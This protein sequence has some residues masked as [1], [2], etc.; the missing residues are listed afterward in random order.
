MSN[1]LPKIDQAGKP[2][3][4]AGQSRDDLDLFTVPGTEIVLTDAG[5]GATVWQWSI[6]DQPPGAA[7]TLTTP[8]AMTTNLTN[9]TVRG[10]YFVQL[11]V[12]GGALPAQVYRIIAGVQID[13][14][15]WVTPP[16]N[17]PLRIPAKG[18]TTEF[19][20]ESSPGAGAN[21]RGWAQ[22][23]DHW[24]RAI[25]AF[26]FGVRAQSGGVGV[27]T[28]PFYTLNFVGMT[29]ADAG[30]GVLNVT[31][32]NGVTVQDE[33]AAVGSRPIINFIGAGVSAVDNPGNNRIDVTIPGGLG[34]IEVRNEG[35][36]PIP[37]GPWSQFQFRVPER[38]DPNYFS[39]ATNACAQPGVGEAD[40]VVTS[41]HHQD[42]F[43]SGGILFFEPLTSSRN[44][45]K[46][47]VVSMAN[48]MTLNFLSLGTSGAQTKVVTQGAIYDT[49]SIPAGMTLSLPATTGKALKL[50]VLEA[51]TS[52]PLVGEVDL[53]VVRTP[54]LPLVITDLHRDFPDRVVTITCSGG[55][56]YLSLDGGPLSLYLSGQ[57]VRL[58]D[59]SGY[60]WVEVF[61]SGAGI[62]GTEMWDIT[63]SM[64]R[65]R[66]FC[67]LA[68]APYW[69]NGAVSTWGVNLGG[70]QWVI[71]ARQFGSI[72]ATELQDTALQVID[73][74]GGDM[75]WQAGVVFNHEEVQ[76]DSANEKHLDAFALVPATSGGPLQEAVQVRGG[77]VWAGGRRYV[78]D[79]AVLVAD[80]GFSDEPICIVAKLSPGGNRGVGITAFQVATGNP[81]DAVRTCLQASKRNPF[82]P[83]M[84][85]ELYV[86]LYFGRV[87]VAG[88]ALIADGRV[89]LRRD[90]AHYGQWTVA[91]RDPSTATEAFLGLSWQSRLGLMIGNNWSTAGKCIAEFGSVAGALAWH[92]ALTGSDNLTPLAPPDSIAQNYPPT[93][94]R[95]IGD[96][97]ETFPIH[98]RNN[99]TVRGEGSPFVFVA[100]SRWWIDYGIP[101][102]EW[103]YFNIGDGYTTNKF[104]FNVELRD[105]SIIMTAYDRAVQG[106]GGAIS[107]ALMIWAGDYNSA[108]TPPPTGSWT[109]RGT[110]QNV[111]VDNVGFD[112]CDVSKMSRNDY[113]AAIC[114][115]DMDGPNA[116][117]WYNGLFIRNCKTPVFA[118]RVGD[119]E[120]AFNGAIYVHMLNPAWSSDIGIEHCRFSVNAFGIMSDVASTLISG[121]LIDSNTIE[122]VLYSMS[123]ITSVTYGVYF[124]AASVSG[125]RVHNNDFILRYSADVSRSIRFGCSLF[126]SVI[127][128]NREIENNG[129][130]SLSSGIALVGN[131]LFRTSVLGNQVRCG[132]NGILIDVPAAYSIQTLR[133][134]DNNVECDG[135]S[136]TTPAGIRILHPS[137]SSTGSVAVEN[138]SVLYYQNGIV[139]EFGSRAESISVAHN[140]VVSRGG[141][142]YADPIGISFTATYLPK[143]VS[144]HG[145]S[146]RDVRRGIYMAIPA[147]ASDV[148]IKDNKID[149]LAMTTEIGSYN[150]RGIHVL[151]TPSADARVG[152]SICDNVIRN[153][154]SFSSLDSL[155]GGGVVVEN[156]DTFLLSD[157]SICGNDIMM[158]S[159]EADMTAVNYPEM[160][161]V[162][163]RGPIRGVQINKNK[164]ANRAVR[165]FGGPLHG[166]VVIL[167]NTAFATPTD[168]EVQINS[169]HITW[170]DAS[171][172]DGVDHS[173]AGVAIMSAFALGFQ[174]ND[175]V[176]NVQSIL[177]D[178]LFVPGCVHGLMVGRA[179]GINGVQIHNNKIHAWKHDVGTESYGVCGTAMWLFTPLDDISIKGNEC[180]GFFRKTQ[181][182][183]A[184]SYWGVISV[185]VYDNSDDWL[186]S[187]SIND[188][189]VINGDG[190]GGAYGPS[191]LAYG[192]HVGY[193]GVTSGSAG[194]R[195]SVCDN[196]VY[197]H[198]DATDAALY[199]AGILV[200][201]IVTVTAASGGSGAVVCGNHIERDSMNGTMTHGLV[202]YGW[203][204]SHFGDN[205]IIYDNI[206]AEGYEVAYT[207][208]VSS[209]TWSSNRAGD[210]TNNGLFLLTNPPY[211]PQPAANNWD[212]A[213]FV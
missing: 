122:T 149:G 171:Y 52:G 69:L 120:R 165:I 28:E 127:E 55:G 79:R 186:A 88:D 185:G 112:M 51:K 40:L 47:S 56:T 91:C 174:I 57:I 195:L 97:L 103:S 160:S 148:S 85:D 194:H 49:T 159:E 168:Y 166:G 131:T 48:P 30:G 188:N 78:V 92:G 205:V 172:L 101:S 130:S 83:N 187:V 21:A 16:I 116:G 110:T 121:L 100:P 193:V 67:H 178:T 107:A 20:V 98:L 65:Q 82:D 208:A 139:I 58:Y 12:D 156:A 75:Q 38:A 8:N 213:A 126:D 206:G 201:S 151:V 211:R 32:M 145:N 24:F 87:N 135:F 134:A 76:F 199:P 153:L 117:G 53:A 190:D 198:L 189:V 133:I 10:S 70:T 26:G 84:L 64:R 129:T 152:L 180:L 158:H 14:P 74:V 3:G 146:V 111:T 27:G 37:G 119:H 183:S 154:L 63:A 18:E 54:A 200:E 35:T 125:L 43:H 7:A 31:G 113:V 86:P 162:L 138:N 132:H 106:A 46:C 175:N 182:G 66:G 176:V 196:Q 94:V 25:A 155:Q 34:G 163:L 164:I 29:V 77:V 197:V 59:P 118:E 157:V 104:V 1:A 68:V 23:L 73:R 41:A 2:A 184:K 144:I 181:W 191:N 50:V 61:C 5:V 210:S 207:G 33:G 39:S 81:I 150:S 42:N 95:V 109:L 142:S 9:A 71:D 60:Y 140:T 36:I 141:A 108:T 22:E 11:V 204:E 212:G 136:G 13:T 99:I 90:V 161:G 4:V 173:A 105:L 96:T 93:T 147:P 143:N 128:G 123:F 170:C 45:L 19:N 17:R 177:E 115:R 114:L 80:F 102:Y 202:N 15:S 62:N 192:I 167:N 89:D 209:T 44:A 203:R 137:T 124:T 6:L 72:G 179:Y 169:N